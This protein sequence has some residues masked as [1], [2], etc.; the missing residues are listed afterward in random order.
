[1]KKLISITLALFVLMSLFTFT[2]SATEYKTG[3]YT[4]NIPDEFI[5]DKA[6]AE[7]NGY[8]DYW[9]TEDY[10]AEVMVWDEEPHDVFDIPK[11]EN[12]D[13]CYGLN[14]TDAVELYNVS[15]EEIVING[16]N[17]S[18][19]RRRITKMETGEKIRFDL[20][21]IDRGEDDYSLSVFTRNRDTYHYADEISKTLE[22][23]PAPEFITPLTVGG[24]SVAFLALSYAVIKTVSKKKE[25]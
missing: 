19:L 20:Y 12:A 8:V 13:I 21:K 7:K 15:S 11:T 17:V 10:R 25:K 5:N 23:D 18:H 22:I 24:A 4:L 14:I 3:A 16:E 2:S 9:H 1:M 6:W